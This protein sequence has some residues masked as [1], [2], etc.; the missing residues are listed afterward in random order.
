MRRILSVLFAVFLLLPVLPARAQNA[1]HAGLYAFKADAYPSMSFGLDVYDA[2][3]N[4]VTGLTA[5]KLTLLEDDQPRPLDALTETQPGVQFVLAINMGDDFAKR[6]ANAVTRYDKLREVLQEW[7]GSHPDAAGDDLSLVSNFGQEVTHQDNA[8]DIKAFLTAD[9]PDPRQ[10]TA[11]LATLSQALDVASDPLPQPGMKRS[12]LLITP[13]IQPE[14]TSNLQS[15]VSRA[16]ELGVRVHVWIVASQDFFTYSGATALK[17]LAIQTGGQYVLFSGSEPMPGVESYLVPLRHSY[18]VA[19]TSGIRQGGSHSLVVN[20]NLNGETVTTSPFSFDL[21]VQPPNPIFVSPP[22]Q[23]LRQSTDPENFNLA[24][25]T[26]LTQTLSIIVEFP[27]GRTR[28]LV[29]TRLYVDGVIAAEN[30]AEPFDTFTWDLSGYTVSGQ[31]L[32]QVEAEDGYGL[33]RKSIPTPVTVTILQPPPGVRTWLTRNVI[34]VVAGAVVLT[35]GVLALVLIPVRHRRRRQAS[36]ARKSAYDPV[37][38]PVTAHVEPRGKKRRLTHREK[39]APASLIRVDGDG[40]PLTATPIPLAG[41]TT[42]GSDPIKASHVLDDASVSPL[43]TRIKQGEDGDFYIKDEK[44][45]AG[46]WVN[47]DPVKEESRRLEH[48]DII[49]IGQ[50]SYRFLLRKPLARPGP[51]VEPQK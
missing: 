31:H 47:F 4:L 23:V 38:Q 16:V 14:E 32:L 26:P 19:Y 11:S 37:T 30:T 33:S 48:A 13:V 39:V 7:A 41:N 21:D 36:P 6:D 34:W 15:L 46:T 18:Q 12:I 44:S 50:L 1:A 17:D 9:Q 29:R 24:T 28:P 49:H 35:G 25:L 10:Q 45:V 2:T 3:G 42:F 51:R 27:D 20:I 8:L 40:Q 5:D 22:S 43:H